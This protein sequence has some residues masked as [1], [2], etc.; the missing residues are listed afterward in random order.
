MPERPAPPWQTVNPAHDL[1]T[2]QPWPARNGQPG[3]PGPG[4]GASGYQQPGEEQ[5]S[6]RALPDSEV[7]Q[8]FSPV[9]SHGASHF[10]PA[11]AAGDDALDEEEEPHFDDEDDRH[12]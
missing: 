9:P 3:G 12:L 5:A 10:G 2:E 11:P 1:G 6:A 8:A 4:A 7:T